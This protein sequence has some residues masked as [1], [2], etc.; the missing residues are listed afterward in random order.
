MGF[1]KTCSYDEVSRSPHLYHEKG[2]EMKEIFPGVFKDG[3]RLYTNNL[4]PGV[5]VYGE[6]LVDNKREW[7]PSRSK[8]GEAIAKGMKEMPIRQGSIILYL[9]A[10]TGTTISHVSDIVGKEGFVY[11]IEF[12]ERVLRSLMDLANQRRNIAAIKADARK[13]EEYRWLEECDVLFC[14][15]A[16]PQETEIAV[17]NAKEFLKKDGYMM[18]AIKSQSIDVTKKP[19][20]VYEEEKKKVEKAGFADVQLINLEP[21]EEKHAMIIARR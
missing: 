13:P 19:Q 15:I 16:D 9:G 11:G 3:N 10:S 17:R 1:S 12:A 4:V 2:F 18:M 8:L 14:D 6:K 21:Y 5:R 20:Q 7:D